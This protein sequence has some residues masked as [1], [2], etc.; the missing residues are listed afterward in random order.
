MFGS[1]E[2]G[3]S[4]RQDFRFLM[5]CSVLTLVNIDSGKKIFDAACRDFIQAVAC[6]RPFIL[7][8]LWRVGK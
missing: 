8:P 3:F 1:V 4:C 6:M 2:D 5:A 7:L